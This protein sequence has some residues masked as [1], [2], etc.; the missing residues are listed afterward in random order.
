VAKI[1]NP[2]V[3]GLDPNPS[4]IP[5]KFCGGSP[6]AEGVLRFCEGVIAAVAGLIPALKLQSAFFEIFGP[7]GIRAMQA[8]AAEASSRGLIVI[9]DV[10]RGDI[11]ETSAAYAAAYLG[12]NA[13]IECDAMT[14]NPYLGWDS[15]E[16]FFQVALEQNK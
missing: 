11:G 6:S 5:N 1:G 2:V 8:A 13:F 7:E 10:K 15:L 4:L 16:P 9:V 12:P 3:V 14:L